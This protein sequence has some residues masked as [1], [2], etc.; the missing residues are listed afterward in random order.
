M[1]G[2]K[3]KTTWKKR[4]LSMFLAVAMISGNLSQAAYAADTGGEK[5]DTEAASADQNQKVI[6]ITEKDIKKILERDEDRRPEVKLSDIPLK[7]TAR[8]QSVLDDL[9]SMTE[10]KILIK[11]QKYG[12][13]VCMIFVEKNGPDFAYMDDEDSEEEPLMDY[14]NII[15]IN[16]ES[17][18]VSFK[19]ELISDTLVYEEATESVFRI[20]GENED[21]ELATDSNAQKATPSDAQKNEDIGIPNATPSDAEK[22]E[23]R[24]EEPSLPAGSGPEESQPETEGQNPGQETTQ[25][26]TTDNPVTDPVEG[27]VQPT[28]EYTAPAP[29]AG[30]TTE[31]DRIP[32]QKNQAPASEKPQSQDTEKKT[33]EETK[34]E[35]EQETE[36]EE[37]KTL[38]ISRHQV[39]ILGSVD[40]EEEAGLI[41]EK[42]EENIT[43]EFHKMLADQGGIV[44]RSRGMNTF[45]I[46]RVATYSLGTKID[47]AIEKYGLPDDPTDNTLRVGDVLLEVKDPNGN[48]IPD[49]SVGAGQDFGINIIYNLY[50]G[51]VYE[52]TSGPRVNLYYAKDVI[53][54]ECYVKITVPEALVINGLDR[55]D[56]GAADEGMAVYKL[57]I[58]T[59]SGTSELVAYFTGNGLTSAGA[60]YSITDQTAVEIVGQ[61]EVV[62]EDGGDPVTFL[63]CDQGYPDQD[64]TTYTCTLTTDD[65]WTVN[66]QNTNDGN[67]GT[68]TGME[69]GKEA[70]LFE[71]EIA[72]GLGT[73]N[74]VT[75]AN[76]DYFTYGRVPFTSYELKDQLTFWERDTEGIDYTE[77][78]EIKPI[79]VKLIPDNGKVDANDEGTWK[80]IT[81]SSSEGKNTSVVTTGQY[82]VKGWEGGDTGYDT[83]DVNAPYYT[84]YKVQ[85]YYDK[86]DFELEY[87][88]SRV[89]SKDAY[90]IENTATITYQLAGV[91]GIKI[92]DHVAVAKYQ[93]VKDHS[94]INLKKFLEIPVKKD[95]R[96]TFQDVPYSKDMG[97]KLKAAYGGTV[98]FSI[99]RMND[100]G[101]F[102]DYKDA[103]I[104]ESGEYENLTDI[105]IGSDS[106]DGSLTFYVEP[107]TYRIRETET[108]SEKLVLSSEKM[109]EN[110]AEE[111]GEGVYVQLEVDKDG[112]EDVV[113]Y[114]AVNSGGVQFVKKGYSYTNHQVDMNT[115]TAVAGVT[116]EI[117]DGK[118]ASAGTAVSNEN[119][120]VEFFP[121]DPGVYTIKEIG[122]PSG[123][124]P[125]DKVYNVTVTK[126]SISV[127]S[128]N[129][130]PQGTI[131]NYPNLDAVTVTKYIDMDPSVTTGGSIKTITDAVFTNI[132][133][134][135]FDNR[136]KVQY[137]NNEN[138]PWADCGTTTYS[139]GANGSFVCD[140]PVYYGGKTVSAGDSPSSSDS[141][142]W[143]RVVEK[144]PDAYTSKAYANVMAN[145]NTFNQTFDPAASGGASVISKPFQ[146]NEP[147]TS[148]SPKEVSIVNIL[149]GTAG[150]E[151]F[152][153]EYKQAPESAGNAAI[154]TVSAGENNAASF[155]LLK[156]TGTQQTPQ[157]EQVGLMVSTDK[158]GKITIPN[159]DVWDSDGN[160][161]QYYWYEVPTDGRTLEVYDSNSTQQGQNRVQTAQLITIDGQ[162]ITGASIAGPFELTAGGSV[163]AYA[164]N[165]L[166]KIP[167]WFNKEVKL[168][169]LSRIVTN[170][171]IVWDDSNMDTQFT[172][173]VYKQDDTEQ[174][175]LDQTVNNKDTPYFLDQ[176]VTYR[177]IE[178]QHPEAYMDYVNESS[179]GFKMTLDGKEY[180]YQE[181]DL[182]QTDI[183]TTGSSLISSSNNNNHIVF[184]NEQKQRFKIDKTVFSSNIDSSQ[185][186]AQSVTTHPEIDMVLYK[187]VQQG[188]VK[189]ADTSV[190]L[191]V[192]TQT[193]T[194]IEP[195]EYFITEPNPPEGCVN[196]AFYLAPGDHTMDWSNP[197]Y[198]DNKDT[199]TD[200]SDDVVYYG[201]YTISNAPNQRDELVTVPI[202]NYQMKGSVEAL[203]IDTSKGAGENFLPNAQIGLYK[204]SAVAGSPVAL[205]EVMNPNTN[206][207][208]VITTDANGKAIFENLPIYDAAG[209]SITY[210]L[211]ED[212]APPKFDLDTSRFEFQLIS[213]GVTRNADKIKDGETTQLNQSIIFRDNPLG[214]IV[215]Q[216]FWYDR[217]DSQFKYDFSKN[218][219]PEV[220]LALFEYDP[221]EDTE[222]TLT[223][224][225]KEIKTTRPE[226]ATVTFKDL[227]RRKAYFVVEMELDSSNPALNSYTLPDGLIALSDE[228]T[229]LQV[230]TQ[231]ES[232]AKDGYGLEGSYNYVAFQPQED[233]E[234][235]A[236]RA[237][238]ILNQRPWVQINLTKWAD[239]ELSQ[240]DETGTPLT[241]EGKQYYYKGID[242]EEKINGAQF[243]LYEIPA[244]R[245]GSD[246]SLIPTEYETLGRLVDTYESGTKLDENGERLDGQFMTTILRSGN[247]YYLREINAGPGC[248]ILDRPQNFVFVP[249]D[250]DDYTGIDESQG[251]IIQY[252]LNAKTDVDAYNYKWV[253][254]EGGSVYTANVKLNKWL[255]QKTTNPEGIET[256]S[257]VPLGGVTFAL[258]IG[259]KTFATLE[260]G[261]DNEWSEG[262]NI[263]GQA[264]SKML[265]FDDIVQQLTDAEKTTN[266][267]DNETEKSI[268]FDLVEVK[269]P[270][271]IKAAQESYKITVKFDSN[272]SINEDYFWEENKADRIRLVNTLMDGYHA[273]VNVFGYV[274]TDEMFEESNQHITDE[275]LAGMSGLNPERLGGVELEL[276]RYDIA[277]EQYVRYN[278]DG[279]HHRLK[280]DTNGNFVFPNGLPEGRYY[281]IET[282]IPQM[283][284][285]KKKPKYYTMYNNIFQKHFTVRPTEDNV[286]DL[287]NP[288]RP[289][290]K[291]TKEVL[292]GRNGV[293]LSGL[294][295]QLESIGDSYEKVN[296]TKIIG[297]GTSTVTF[298][299]IYPNSKFKLTES[300]GTNT[301]ASQNVSETYQSILNT[302][303]FALGYR[304]MIDSDGQTVYLEIHKGSL[305]LTTGNEYMAQFTM[306]NPRKGSLLLTKVDGDDPN[307]KLQGA[308][309]SYE[310]TPFADND[311]NGNQEVIYPSGTA[312]AEIITSAGL[313]NRNWAHIG[314]SDVTAENGKVT[315]DNLDPGWYRIK[316]E[317]APT[318]Y[319][320]DYLDNGSPMTYYVAVTAD[321]GT[322]HTY[323]SN[324]LVTA[325]S[326]PNRKPVDLKITKELAYGGLSDKSAVPSS[327]KFQL[328]KGISA[329]AAVLV[330]GKSVTIASDAFPEN[331]TG[332]KTA[333]A[334]IS[335]IPQLTEA[336]QTAGVNYYLKEEV[337][338]ASDWQL[339]DAEIKNATQDPTEP[340]FTPL[341]IENGTITLQG[342][343]SKDEVDITV[344][345]QY[346]KAEIVLKKVKAVEVGETA[347]P[348]DE[349]VFAL[350]NTRGEGTSVPS[351]DRK[352]PGVTVAPANGGS[353]IYTISNI[354]V[355]VTTGSSTY[356]L[357]EVTAPETYYVRRTEPIEV[358][359][360]P[361]ERLSYET[362]EGTGD[363]NPLLVT[364]ESGVDI[365][366]V[367]YPDIHDKESE[368][369]IVMGSESGVKFDL[370]V[371]DISQTEPGLWTK[372][373]GGP[374][375]PDETTGKMTWTGLKLADRQ[376]A[377][378][379]HEITTG[380]YKNYTLESIYLND[381]KQEGEDTFEGKT[382]HILGDMTAGGEMEFQAYNKPATQIRIQKKNVE[383]LSGSAPEATFKILTADGQLVVEEGIKTESVA[384]KD[385]SE[386]IVQLKEGAY[387]LEETQTAPGY[388]LIPDD[389]RVV[390]RQSITVP[391]ETNTYTFTNTKVDPALNLEK[392]VTAVGETPVTDGAAAVENLWWT[393]EQRVSY[394]IKPELIDNNFTDQGNFAALKKFKVVDSGL[395]ML[396]GEVELQYDIYTK[397][398]Y[399]FAGLTI[400]KPTHESYL[401]DE[402]GVKIDAGAIT[403]ELKL[404]G[405]DDSQVGD[406]MTYTFTD[407]QSWTPSLPEGTK[408]KSFEIQYYDQALQTA[409]GSKYALAQNFNPGT[410]EADVILYQQPYNAD[411]NQVIDTVRNNVSSSADYVMY[412]QNGE[413]SSKVVTAYT[414]ADVRVLPPDTPTISI[415]LDVVNVKSTGVETGAKVDINDTLR[416]TMSLTNVSD[417][418]ITSK[419]V[420][421][422]LVNRFP[423][424]V[425]PD[426]SSIKVYVNDIDVS[427]TGV[428]VKRQTVNAEDGYTYLLIS[429]K[430]TVLET[431]GTVRAEVDTK[432]TNA[433]I[434]NGGDIRD[435][436][437]VTSGQ[438]FNPFGM[439]PGGASFKW[440]QEAQGGQGSSVRWPDYS[441]ETGTISIDN[442]VKN[443]TLYTGS[444]NGY[445]HT[446]CQN[447][448]STSNNV[449]LLKEGHGDL[450]APEVYVS[451]EVGAKISSQDGKITYHLT[452]KN[453]SDSEMV[454]TKLRILDMLP[455]K[456]EKED[457]RGETRLSNWT[458]KLDTEVQPE[459]YRIGKNGE[460]A[461]IKI[462]KTYYLNDETSLTKEVLT[463]YGDPEGNG[464]LS[465]DA[466]SAAENAV[467]VMFDIELNAPLASNE[468]VMIEFGAKTPVLNE[469]EL[470]SLSHT[471][472]TNNFSTC[473][474]YKDSKSQANDKLSINILHS[475]L[476][477]V[478]LQPGRTGVGGHIWI[479]ANG[480]GIQ[481]DDKYNDTTSILSDLKTLIKNNYFNV[482][483]NWYN[484]EG[485]HIY[486]GKVPAAQG[487]LP[488]IPNDSETRTGVIDEEGKFLFSGLFSSKSNGK[489]LYEKASG[490]EDNT[491]WNKLQL[492]ALFKPYT[493]YQLMITTAKEMPEGLKGM[494]LEKTITAAK[495]DGTINRDSG[496]SRKPSELSTTY[497]DE[498]KDNN[499]IKTNDAYQSEEFFLWTDPVWDQT[500]DFGVIPY[501]NLT[502][503]KQNKDK[504]ALSDVTFAL[505]GPFETTEEAKA[506]DLSGANDQSDKF[507]DRQSTDINGM[508]SFSNLL[509]YLPYVL[510]EENTQD[511]YMLKG[512]TASAEGY[513]VV[514]KS[515][516]PEEASWVLEYGVSDVTVT[517]QYG[518]GTLKVTKT[519]A[520]T[521]QALAGAEFELK[522]DK[523]NVENAWDTVL[524]QVREQTQ[525]APAGWEGVEII[526]TQDGTLRFTLTGT[527]DDQGVSDGTAVLGDL[528]YG[529]YTLTE[530]KAPDGYILGDEPQTRTFTINLADRT[531]SYTT[532]DMA[533]EEDSQGTIDNEPHHVR[534]VKVRQNDTATRL[535]GAEFIMRSQSQ[536]YVLL[537]EGNFNGYTQNEAEASRF[538]SDENGEFIIKRLPVDT[539][540]IIEKTA[541]SG[542]YINS[543][544]SPFTTDGITSLTVQIGDQQITYGGGSGGG[545]GGSSTTGRHAVTIVDSDVPLA[546]LPDVPQ[547]T[548]LDDEVPLAGLPKTG[549]SLNRVRIASMVM[550]AISGIFLMMEKRKS[551]KE[552]D[553]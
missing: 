380:Q 353:G 358:T 460:R 313:G 235:D 389:Q 363:V 38:S 320:K 547:V 234:A 539:Y 211:K 339:T 519:D 72:V 159:L 245:V 226:D 326:I 288:E 112:A 204:K 413:Q 187:A 419:M 249:G 75:S 179:S 56:D 545:G 114:N 361:G 391:G 514:V 386:A 154:T 393:K 368:S 478:T 354:P 395:V 33:K 232:G 427:E 254:G 100:E 494:T 330:N 517:N 64:T 253:E 416:Y 487:T 388:N 464:W 452:A 251:K 143:Y 492:D 29:E 332:G 46:V 40:N 496:Q 35:T 28:P 518:T 318:G 439:N 99:Q 180:Y 548:I 406:F 428:E 32:E 334:T 505:Y 246:L 212:V 227:D 71:Y 402:N 372:V 20:V 449:T 13:S 142:S 360:H 55:L 298:E 110:G 465:A 534:V 438:V 290:L 443:N 322:G 299:G 57:P 134:T 415:D 350:Y 512:A 53:E 9:L 408:I 371:R 155:Y 420:S 515:E 549:E 264:M 550:M 454:V 516:D 173:E 141:R 291:V 535:A 94:Q 444:Q 307:Q 241:F 319:I 396:A 39:D 194:W 527:A 213:G 265:Y 474:H 506:F 528:P 137:S 499:F 344:T 513:N 302:Q 97:E 83:T 207:R 278:Y 77:R 384:D 272:G 221:A 541:P 279:E 405:F 107:G 231:G 244:E 538:R 61:F 216:K 214:T 176:G 323:E 162:S 424:G 470:K 305:P 125:D 117:F 459:A 135:T 481:D 365:S 501:R 30:S 6:K 205:D 192:H 484:A 359:V 109:K 68:L 315:I 70:V 196:P 434:N 540:Q 175:V 104:L 364:N 163:S 106:D 475:N 508:I 15:T 177:V 25:N 81:V 398:N 289:A 257:Y 524:A 375:S 10:D 105:T 59:T 300:V 220:R 266:V 440:S 102:E 542:Y 275:Y 210:V 546:I 404:Y 230:V 262:E 157:Y 259:S 373:E 490:E 103:Q 495:G 385:Y 532:D 49:F 73:Q 551:R 128:Y 283:V 509:Y 357:Y 422:I 11:K 168:T 374:K 247:I 552:N 152:V 472:D 51:P 17:S 544:I 23:T 281:L 123:Y 338:K 297:Q 456:S 362:P 12:D 412:N 431:G 52:T 18:P 89:P 189:Q 219:L 292:S 146:M 215:V 280:T 242:P 497:S 178:K 186:I 42:D 304:R 489:S 533:L 269:A 327:V 317:K 14:L 430:G 22:D 21:L 200:K 479:D 425:V 209:N 237:E 310:F 185:S 54:S 366:L 507:V 169:G 543:N 295:F 190:G 392:K 145:G 129:S 435:Q 312:T 88:D 426:D 174:W 267:V 170:S 222:E 229:S 273:E 417:S 502:V 258:R 376:Y 224:T 340:T 120:V 531:I 285:D 156:Q 451:D 421:P 121:L 48:T 201:P 223:A 525:G 153:S 462:K 44:V 140:L 256:T 240:K 522:A 442:L 381:A 8:K 453:T 433:I 24:P 261:L 347:T 183:V 195:G 387:I 455:R 503:K 403:A 260:T 336:E 34:K 66:K 225:R 115:A 485:D 504:Q 16:G 1:I 171:K 118:G 351:D 482:G 36:A 166:Q 316:E 98:S 352:V 407:D 274:P 473:Y 248:E 270:D 92:Q 306:K 149:R 411:A 341:T 95:G 167:V 432:V 491:I 397:N 238:E 203:K 164:Y 335:G 355:D 483:L 324:G 476:V 133:T 206:Q 184:K 441:Q 418:G 414:S 236:P 119:G 255:E 511:D 458:L 321:M 217:W 394:S 500:K 113:F 493:Y 529:T 69:D 60:E 161:I 85:A 346:A 228:I 158:N 446:Y 197:Y 62:D 468:S 252:H 50:D 536:G 329:D 96:V 3:K 457:F 5:V 67:W 193:E 486:S 126:E 301:S 369:A 331:A 342:F 471:Y 130:E 93:Y 370:Y 467:G 150:L 277:T 41:S 132:D 383:G 445:A 63:F 553:Q 325:N 303:E 461:E 537:K 111:D 520:E 82:A 429:L 311:F 293:D 480:N 377:V 37:V 86:K 84:K 287:Y 526:E 188:T 469:E 437:F 488:D 127:P 139:L 138:G 423:K 263:T 101:T 401:L 276:Y 448:F 356:Y 47:M 202:T 328:Y 27:D 286:V 378:Y 87:Y 79:E 294:T 78:S 284:T 309:F 436:L 144:V 147:G 43:E 390:T 447:E 136:F 199:S 7:G 349:A 90:K 466:W 409:T 181:L 122:A 4:L 2:L 530:T 382:L 314:V 58:N 296:V 108:T 19:V 76:S 131:Y 74:V 198:I 367:K 208:Y 463:K 498:T 80:T 343:T 345:N 45:S 477:S 400:P 65:Q 233:S 218:E 510:V 271:R 523:T 116:F 151:K 379:E 148:A 268:T 250:E 191:T 348:L 31:T 308:T 239:R 91:E 243:E 521:R 160:K 450:D 165:V 172:F 337:T 124:I 399:S 182:S 282:K 26:P 333:Q 410:I